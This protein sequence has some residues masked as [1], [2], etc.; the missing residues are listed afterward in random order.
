MADGFVKKV[1]VF[2]E[3]EHGGQP[4]RLVNL[5]AGPDELQTINKDIGDTD[6]RPETRCYVHGVLC[7]RIRELSTL[8]AERKP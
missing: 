6:W 7:S 2:D 5:G 1:T 8:S 3:W 4:M